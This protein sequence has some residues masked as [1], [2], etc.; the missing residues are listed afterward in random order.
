MGLQPDPYI[1]AFLKATAVEGKQQSA[2][3][4]FVMRILGL[5]VSPEA[6]VHFL[7]PEGGQAADCSPAACHA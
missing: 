4:Q 7:Y 2:V 3:T 5:E 6:Y 1:D